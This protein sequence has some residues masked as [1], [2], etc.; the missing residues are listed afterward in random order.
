[1]LDMDEFAHHGIDANY[2]EFSHLERM[3]PHG[4]PADF[5][6]FD[7]QSNCQEIMEIGNASTQIAKIYF[8][9]HVVKT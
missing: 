6:I 4:K 5:L 9:F 1:M 3:K 2:S 8:Y 7:K